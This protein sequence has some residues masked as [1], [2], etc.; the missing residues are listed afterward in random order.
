MII[1]F[2]CSSIVPTVTDPKRPLSFIDTAVYR[3]SDVTASWLFK[4]LVSA[5]LGLSQIAWIYVPIMA[6]W[7]FG[8]WRLGQLYMGMRS[9]LKSDED[10]GPATQPVSSDG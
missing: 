5:G 1:N 2:P 4:G 10:D 9:R 7:G 8:A 6:V 3:G